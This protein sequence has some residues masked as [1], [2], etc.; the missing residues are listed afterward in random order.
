MS[1]CVH[2]QFRYLKIRYVMLLIFLRLNFIETRWFTEGSVTRFAPGLWKILPGKL[3]G[4][5]MLSL[6]LGWI[7]TIVW[8]STKIKC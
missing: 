5:G 6:R 4:K 2:F 1:E 8:M 7:S 3:C